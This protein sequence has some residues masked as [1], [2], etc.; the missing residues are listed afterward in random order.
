MTRASR[1]RTRNSDPLMNAP[2]NYSDD[3]LID[4][5][6]TCLNIDQAA[7]ALNVSRGWLFPRAK[8]LEREGKIIPKS[9]MPAYFKPKEDE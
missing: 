6:T 8:R 3:E 4:E 7:R 9:V 1:N 2:I 5:L